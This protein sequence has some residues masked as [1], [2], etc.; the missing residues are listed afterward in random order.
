MRNGVDIS[1]KNKRK[2]GN[3]YN[4]KINKT[5]NYLLAYNN[6]PAI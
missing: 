1:C 6:N 3:Y 4:S 2:K 5:N